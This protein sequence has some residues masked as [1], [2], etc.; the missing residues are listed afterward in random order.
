MGFVKGSLHKKIVAVFTLLFMLGMAGQA[1][2]GTTT[3]AGTVNSVTAITANELIDTSADGL[4]GSLDAGTGA[5]WGAM[6]IDH[7]STLFILD[8]GG[9]VSTALVA[10]IEILSGKMKLFQNFAVTRGHETFTR[11]SA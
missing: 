3:I 7:N 6:D 10:A 11:R 5:A 9:G 1:S 8:A 4:Y 2:A